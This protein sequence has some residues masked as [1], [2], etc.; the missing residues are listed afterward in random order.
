MDDIDYIALKSKID[1]V[2]RLNIKL[3]KEKKNMVKSIRHYKRVIRG[4]K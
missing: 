4:Y 1:E 2:T 3:Q